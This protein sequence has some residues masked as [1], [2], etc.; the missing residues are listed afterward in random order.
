MNRFY[1]GIVATLN[2]VAFASYAA[3]QQLTGTWLPVGTDDWNVAE[4]WDVGGQFSEVPVGEFGDHALVGNGGTAVVAE[5]VPSVANLTINGGSSLLL[6]DGGVLA[7]IEPEGLV[8][9]NLVL[10]GGS[11]IVYDGG[12]ELS[13]DLDAVN[14]G[15]VAFQGGGVLNVGRNYSGGGAVEVD[16]GEVSN[17]VINVTGRATLGGAL[18][19]SFNNVESIEF[20]DSWGV[21]ASDD[22]VGEFT[23]DPTFSDNLPSGLYF[24][25]SNIEGVASLEVANRLVLT[26]NRDTGAVTASNVAGETISVQGY[27]IG[28]PSGLLA[29]D[30]WSSLQDAGIPGFEEANPS[31]SYLSELNLFG[32]APLEVGE[33]QSLGN[34]YTPGPQGPSEID[35]F[36]EYV[37]DNGNVVTG[38]INYEGAVADLVLRV[39]EAGQAALLTESP[40]FEADIQGYSILS[41]SGSLTPGNW[42]SLQDGG[43]SGWEEANP[44]SSAISELNLGE[45]SRVDDNVLLGLGGVFDVAGEQDLLL[46]YVTTAGDVLF[47]TVEYGP[48]PDIEPLVPGDVNG[49]GMVDLVDF[50]ILKGNFGNSGLDV[51]R[52]D[53]DLNGDMSID[54]VDFNIL[55]ENFGTSGAVPEPAAWSMLLVAA[56]VLVVKRRLS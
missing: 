5:E 30:G 34:A 23:I 45:F 55:K 51:M 2:L 52:G 4:N 8:G 6:Q 33:S 39:D 28:S 22:I 24:R 7:A 11:Q 21:L 29:P 3:A 47:G 10:G 40:F 32:A 25:S 31:A 36:F 20:G 18:V 27:T 54:L 43:V 46:E 41:P 16:L 53:G 48:L 49:D 56:S 19:P 50:N 38:E 44:T 17:P 37:T 35:L 42:M 15:A 13:T 14:N 26:V 9:G 1:H 12:G